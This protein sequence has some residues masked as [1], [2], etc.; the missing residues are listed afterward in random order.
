LL[1][2]KD[3]QMLR[4]NMRQEMITE[5]ELMSK[6]REQGV[7]NVSE[8]KKAYLEG[9]GQVSVITDDSKGGGGGGP[10]KAIP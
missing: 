5:D 6:L 9:D 1:L 4:R 7:E 2:I 3:G 8:V 10:K